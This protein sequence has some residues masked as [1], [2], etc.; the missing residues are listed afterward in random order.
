MITKWHACINAKWES[1]MD[2]RLPT[3]YISKC[4]NHWWTIHIKHDF[5]SHFN[6]HFF[7]IV[8]CLYWRSMFHMAH[9]LKLGKFMMNTYCSENMLWFKHWATFSIQIHQNCYQQ[10]DHP[11][12][13][14]IQYPLNTNILT[15]ACNCFYNDCILLIFLSYFLILYFLSI[16]FSATRLNSNNLF[17]GVLQV[18][19]SPWNLSTSNNTCMCSLN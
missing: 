12:I 7:K 17:S 18:S 1:C 8:Q 2:M 3:C 14:Y 9:I 16:L 19:S 13:P 6:L 5:F 10:N 4:F 11:Q 15:Y